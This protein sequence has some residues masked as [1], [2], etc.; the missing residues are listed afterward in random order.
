MPR[1][2]L[3]AKYTPVDTDR[4]YIVPGG[5]PKQKGTIAA[6][7]FS[8][9]DDGM[10]VGDLL[11]RANNAKFPRKHSLHWDI[12]HKLVRIVTKEGVERTFS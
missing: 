3:Y 10:T 12:A 7:L 8:L 6:A 9:Y 4:I 1:S 5:R 2:T 11:K